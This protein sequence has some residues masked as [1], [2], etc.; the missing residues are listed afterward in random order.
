MI[1]SQSI[2]K[3]WHSINVNEISEF[4]FVGLSKE[5]EPALNVGFNSTGKRCLIL[6]LPL[7]YV[8]DINSVTKENLSIEHIQESNYIVIQLM[9]GAYY[10]LFNDLIL[11]LFHKIKDIAPVEEYAKEFVLSFGKWV[12]FFEN[13][14]GSKLSEHEI[15]GLY[16]EIFVLNRFLNNSN[17]SG[18]NDV[19]NGWVGLYDARNDFQFQ[20]KNIEVKTKEESKSYVSISSEYQLEVETGK[21]LELNVISV[22]TDYEKGKSI[23]ELLKLT[24]TLIR[25]K[26]GDLSI[27]YK[28]LNEKKLTIESTKEYNNYRFSVLKSTT[29]NC[30]HDSFPKLTSFNTPAEISNLTYNLKVSDL[31]ESLIE[32]INY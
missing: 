20:F 11:S 24:V 16:G 17:S 21:E 6:E 25:E 30:G 2:E 26:I 13:K 29:F 18:I 7:D 9:N 8:L 31:T 3:K 14:I 10:D 27:L 15:K 5:C 28:A 22:K 32:E 1:N 23:Y 19:L 12:E 4:R